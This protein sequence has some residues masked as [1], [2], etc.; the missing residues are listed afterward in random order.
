MNKAEAKAQINNLREKIRYH[1]HRY[2]VLDNPEIPDSE[3]DRLYKSL[4]ELEQKHPE[5]ITDDSPT[6]RV[7]GEPLPEFGKVTHVVPMLSLTNAF[8]AQDVRDFH[9]R[10]TENIGRNEVEYVAEPKLDGLAIS[11][12]YVKGVLQ[13]AGTRG[14]GMTG[15]DVTHNVRTIEAV[16]LKLRGEDYPGILEVRGEIFMTRK[17]FEVLNARQKEK[18]EKTFANPRNAAAGSLRQLDPRITA[19]RPLNIIFYGLGEV[20]GS[21]AFT[22]H[23]QMLMKLRDW[24]LRVNPEMALVLGSE[25]CLAY[26]DSLQNKRNNLPYDIDGVVYKVNSFADQQHLGSISRAPRW[27]IAHKFPAEEELTRVLSIDVQVGRT[28]R[29]TPVARLAPVLVGGATVTNATLHNQDEIDRKDVRVGDAVIIRRAGDVIPEIVS[30][31]KT[32]RKKGARRF[33]IPAKC[34]VC[35]SEVVRLDNEADARCT[36]GLYCDAQR[37]EA[38]KHYASRRAMDIEGL[39]DKLVEQLDSQGL[40]HDV[41]DLYSLN[42]EELAALERMGE[43]SADNLLASLEI[44]KSTTL[45]RFLFALGIRQV[46]EATALVLANRF[47]GLDELMQADRDALQAVPDVGPVVAESIQAFFHERHNKQV[48]NKLLKAGVNW[49]VINPAK[50][51]KQPLTG[52]TYVLTGTL[53]TM[54]RSEAKSC[55]Q[56]LGAKVAGSVSA[57]T[58]IVVAG[59]AAGSKATK[60]ESL[61]ITIIDEAAFRKLLSSHGV[62]LT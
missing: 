38:I 15:E 44:S 60:A 42:R 62:S 4:Q 25:G 61:G 35:G 56:S 41:A 2:Y 17:G 20:R 7:G 26:Y 24:G 31:V 13:S 12:R 28:G 34:P 58:N 5:L 55:L 30:S 29:I 22:S 18:K 45:P 49:P 40:I 27:A 33:K 47:G 23:H 19:S 3:Y 43:K 1:N 8:T 9:R 11:L 48:I 53:Y 52:Q 39:G 21:S 14:D 6:Q 16:P 10:V 54:T 51:T 57:K 46:G 32:R 50:D 37:C 59:E 36:G